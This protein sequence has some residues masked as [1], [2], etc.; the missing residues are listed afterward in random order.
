MSNDEI[1]TVF[2]GVHIVVVIARFGIVAVAADVMVA[3]AAVNLNLHFSID[4]I[5]FPF[6]AP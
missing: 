1:K 5:L 6:H 3:E 4:K 2:R